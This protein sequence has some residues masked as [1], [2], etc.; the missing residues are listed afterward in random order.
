M[1]FTGSQTGV[2]ASIKFKP[3]LIQIFLSHKGI[4][5]FDDI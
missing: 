1:N 5:G 2:K 3:I 4:F